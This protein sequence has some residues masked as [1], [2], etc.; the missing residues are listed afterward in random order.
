[1]PNDRRKLTQLLDNVDNNRPSSHRRTNR[2]TNE[3]S[4]M[5][6]Y[7]RK[8]RKGEYQYITEDIDNRFSTTQPNWTKYVAVLHKLVADEV[9][10]HRSGSS[11]PLAS[12]MLDRLSGDCEDQTV[13]LS[14]LFVAAGFDVRIILVEHM[15]DKNCHLLPQVRIPEDTDTG[16]DRLREAYD[17]LFGWRPGKMAWTRINGDPYLIADAEWSS[18]VGDRSSLTGDYIKETSSGW[19]WHN[20]M[21]KWMVDSKTS[22]S[23]GFSVQK[24]KTA[25][26]KSSSSRRRKKGFFDQLDEVADAIAESM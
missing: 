8:I 22:H 25:S 9:D 13:L 12:E 20:I 26:S 3:P 2:E 10:Y 17:E 15:G 23:Q 21:E 6:D 18:Y 16:T 4:T 14:N 7:T 1:M 5:K 24:K 11:V 19:S